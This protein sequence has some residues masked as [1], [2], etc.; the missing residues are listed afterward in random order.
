[1]QE[2]SGF[3]D[4]LGRDR[5]CRRWAFTVGMKNCCAKNDNPTIPLNPDGTR[6]AKKVMPVLASKQK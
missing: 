6:E 4:Q 3:V 1:M 2:P 5:W